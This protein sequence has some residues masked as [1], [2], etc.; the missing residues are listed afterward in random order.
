MTMRM[1]LMSCQ[2]L[3]ILSSDFMTH[4]MPKFPLSCSHLI[5]TRQLS[6][7]FTI[8]YCIHNHLIFISFIILSFIYILLFSFSNLYLINFIVEVPDNLT[9][10]FLPGSKLLQSD[11]KKKKRRRMKQR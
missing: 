11:K 1:R 2:N 8:S 7:S 4:F 5:A 3:M 9:S 6:S 10:L